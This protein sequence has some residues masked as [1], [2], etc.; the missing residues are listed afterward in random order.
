MAGDREVI[1]RGVEGNGEPRKKETIR[2][3][4]ERAEEAGKQK[5]RGG[6]KKERRCSAM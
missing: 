5:S 2:E 4:R 6:K 1:E 3:H